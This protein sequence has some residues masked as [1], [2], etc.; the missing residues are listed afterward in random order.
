MSWVSDG[1][2]TSLGLRLE[3]GVPVRLRGSLDKT[4][5]L[6]LGDTIEIVLEREHVEALRE[7][8]TA[9]LGDMVRAE[10]AETL[11]HDAFDAGVQARRAGELALARVEVARRVGADEQAEWAHRAG[12]AAIEAAERASRAVRAAG[13]A[14]DLADEAAEDAVRA[15]D[16][17]KAAGQL[18]GKS[19]EPALT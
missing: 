3:A 7:Q 15:A 5:F 1:V 14:I 10:A 9:A 2:V 6:N 12:R 11:V 13:E 17:V 16:A 19:E 8:T 18:A 4:A